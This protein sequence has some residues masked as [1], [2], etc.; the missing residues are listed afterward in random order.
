MHKSGVSLSRL[1]Q[2]YL[3]L[4]KVKLKAQLLLVLGLYTGIMSAGTY[5]TVD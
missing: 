4:D 2:E 5:H 1:E 3:L